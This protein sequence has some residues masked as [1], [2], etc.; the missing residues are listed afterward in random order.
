MS[1]RT[2]YYQ[3]NRETILNWLKDKARNTENYLKKKKKYKDNMEE[4]DI[5]IC[6]KKIN[7][8]L[9]NIKKKLL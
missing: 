6:L 9:K 4:I 8:D 7:K 5:A 2:T 3:K 1:D